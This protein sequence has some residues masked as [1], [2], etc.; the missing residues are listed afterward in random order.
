M[1]GVAMKAL[2]I[3]LHHMPPVAGFVGLSVPEMEG[4]PDA[5]APECVAY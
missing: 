3:Q 5:F 1:K 2:K 4:V